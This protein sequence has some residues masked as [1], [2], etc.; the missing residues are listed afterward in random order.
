MSTEEYTLTQTAQ[1]TTDDR[2]LDSE[3]LS[4]IFA[5]DRARTLAHSLKAC[6]RPVELDELAREVAAAET[7]TDAA[8]VGADRHERTLVSLY[9]TELPPM[10]E[11]GL[12]DVTREDGVVVEAGDAL[13]E[14]D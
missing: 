11:A 1:P 13:V 14:L 6:D 4:E 7:D 8:V 5:R 12:V 2:T 9:E 10:E 3:T